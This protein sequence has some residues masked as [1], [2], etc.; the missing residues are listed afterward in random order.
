MTARAFSLLTVKNFFFFSP[1]AAAL[2]FLCVPGLSIDKR[3]LCFY[4]E[5]VRNLN[6]QDIVHIYCIIYNR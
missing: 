1:C 2:F 3:V 5:Y 4:N 6:A